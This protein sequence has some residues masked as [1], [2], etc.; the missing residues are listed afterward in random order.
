IQQAS[1]TTSSEV[2][3]KV[4]ISLDKSAEEIKP[5]MNLKVKYII[6]KQ[7]NVFAVPSNSIYE[8]NGKSFMLVLD[9]K[10]ITTVREIEVSVDSNNDYETVI[11]GETLNEKLR[12][13]NSPDLY[14]P[15]TE[16]RLTETAP[17]GTGE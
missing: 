8:K 13:L 9:D 4:I 1:T 11:K 6:E 15:G 16:I 5:D 12:V 3:Y 14:T 7:E 2:L 10:E 17:N